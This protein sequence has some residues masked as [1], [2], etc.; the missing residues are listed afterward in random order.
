MAIESVSRRQIQL[1]EWQHSFHLFVQN[2]LTVI[3]TIL[4]IIL[5]VAAAFP[6]LLTKHDPILPNYDAILEAPSRAHLFGTDEFGRD[7][8]ARVVYGARVSVQTAFLV[9]TIA[10]LL[11]VPLGIIAGFMGGKIDET[12]MRITDVFL[13]IPGLI[14]AMV[15]SA[16]LGP[17]LRNVMIALALVWWP[18]FCRVARG[19][20]I[21]IRESTYIEAARCLG[22]SRSR[23]MLTHV[24]PNSLS[25]IV[26]LAT[27]DMGSVILTAAGL[28]FLGF[29]AQ[30]PTPEWGVM[31]TTARS[32]LSDAWWYITFPGAAIFM[33]VMA[34]NLIGDGLRT[35]MDPR[36]RK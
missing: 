3:G 9:L 20:A 21:S 33:T 27:L 11:G 1:K 15:I 30:P 7:I 13:A 16:S 24:L 6:Q 18:S 22:V 4:V 26:V 12:I 8:F 28:S 34:F 10:L 32:H 35:I 31:V 17:S 23:I 36:S 14:L 29:G 25:P 19:Q 5:L 2:P